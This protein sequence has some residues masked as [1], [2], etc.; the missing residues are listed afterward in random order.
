MPI[1]ETGYRSHFVPMGSVAASG[2]K[3]AAAFVQAW[4]EHEAKKTGWNGAQ[5]ALF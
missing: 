5:L 3:N 2:Y 1:T 4:L